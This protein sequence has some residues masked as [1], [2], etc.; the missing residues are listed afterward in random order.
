MKFVFKDEE[1]VAIRKVGPNFVY[2]L[3]RKRISS[4]FIPKGKSL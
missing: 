3:S 4:G 2:I 1:T